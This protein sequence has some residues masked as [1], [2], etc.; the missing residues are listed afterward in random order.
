MRDKR[1]TQGERI[2]TGE[3]QKRFGGAVAPLP[4]FF[5]PESHVTPWCK[6]LAG[7]RLLS[8]APPHPFC[9]LWIRPQSQGTP[10]PRRGLPVPK[11]AAPLRSH[12]AISPLTRV[13]SQP[14]SGPALPHPSGLTSRGRPQP[15]SF[16]LLLSSVPL[17]NV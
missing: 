14:S 2:R 6:P 13:S 8:E 12:C 9:C 15:L 3:N 17:V 10:L 16:N 5:K 4:V 7:P 1:V 11:Q